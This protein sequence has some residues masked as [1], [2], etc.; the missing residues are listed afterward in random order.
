MLDDPA[1]EAWPREIEVVDS[2][3][4]GEPTRVVLSGWPQPEGST[5]ALRCASLC[6]TQ[7][8]LRRAV[9]CEPRGHAAVVGALVTPAVEPGS[10]CGVIFFDNA[11]ALGMCGHGL[12]GLV[13]TLAWLARVEPGE[14]YVDT[15]A[16]TVSAQLAADGGVTLR[17]VP[18][19]VEALDVSVDVPGLGRVTGDV[20]WGGNWFFL[21]EL[22]GE[23]IGMQN[24]T[25]LT[26]C[27]HAIRNAL[28]EA[29]IVGAGG[30]TIDHV[31]LFGAPSGPH[32]DSRNFVLC[33]SG[34]YDRSP[35]GTGTSAKLAV[36]HARG[37]LS[38]GERWR[39]ESVTGGMFEGWLSQEGDRLVPHI[40]GRAFVTGRATL[41]LDDRDPLRAGIA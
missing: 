1:R 37:Q 21:T 10:T 34:T 26:A 29:G 12:I 14:L 17:N 27:A 13:S 18:A 19:R 15:P 22:K 16:G 31:E 20:A 4:E 2:H 40:R 3:T 8:H 24:L 25:R 41:H 23:A 39:Q 9:V 35:C 11:G 30:A 6:A 38:L 33:P 5:M 32:A 36:L 28:V 7:D